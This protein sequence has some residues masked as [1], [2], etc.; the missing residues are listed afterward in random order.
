MKD[1]EFYDKADK[2]FSECLS[3]TP[4]K[5][6]RVKDLANNKIFKKSEMAYHKLFFDSD[7]NIYKIN[8]NNGVLIRVDNENFKAVVL[9]V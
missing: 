8:D 9:E 3:Y 4:K 5:V 2:M 7:L 6:V 1:R